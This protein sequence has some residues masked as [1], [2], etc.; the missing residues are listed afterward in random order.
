[1][2]QPGSL[3]PFA[4][5]GWGIMEA[6]IPSSG[7]CHCLEQQRLWLPY[8]FQHW[9]LC[10]CVH[11]RRK[12][13]RNLLRTPQRTEGIKKVI[14]IWQWIAITSFIPSVI[15]GALRR[16]LQGSPHPPPQPSSATDK[17]ITA[18]V[19]PSS[20]PEGCIAAF[21]LSPHTLAACTY[22]SRRVWKPLH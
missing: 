9:A 16:I 20:N 1:M 10:G 12:P 17:A 2:P 6:T 7:S 19:P 8:L 3:C 15:C 5:K 21:A 4:F 14:M 11:V 18:L 13:C 22:N